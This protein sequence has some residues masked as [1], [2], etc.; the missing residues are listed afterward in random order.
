[1]IAATGLLLRITSPYDRARLALGRAA[2]LENGILLEPLPETDGV[3][4]AGDIVV[5]V[6]GEAITL[7]ADRLL[8]VRWPDRSVPPPVISTYSVVRGDAQ[9]EV[10]VQRSAH[11]LWEDIAHQWGAVIFLT[12]SLFLAFY[13][14]R[15][16][17]QMLAARLFCMAYCAMWV[18]GSGLIIGVHV[19]D[20]VDAGEFWIHRLVIRNFYLLSRI[21]LLHFALIFP[22]PLP[23]LSR[24]SRLASLYLLPY[25]AGFLFVFLLRPLAGSSL[26]WWGWWPLMERALDALYMALF[27]AVLWWRYQRAQP[28]SVVWQQLRWPVAAA[29]IAGGAAILAGFLP[30]IITGKPLVSYNWLTVLGLLVPISLVRAILYDHLFDIDTFINRTLVYAAL[31][32]VMAGI[33]VTVVGVLGHRIHPD[34][35]QQSTAEFLLYL[36]GAALVAIL[37]QPLHA[38]LQRAVNRLMYGERDDPYAVLSKLGQKLEESLV[39]ETVLPIIAE[40]VV[41]ALKLPYAA[42]A[43]REGNEFA[44]VAT[45]GL[46]GRN[47]TELPLIF[48]GEK[49]GQLLVSPRPGEAFHPAEMR[50]LADI[51]HQAGPAVHNLRLNADLHHSRQQIVTA[52]EEERRRLRG[53]LH[54]GL[55]PSLATQGLKLGAV[56]EL[57]RRDADA[58]ERLLDQMM[59]QNQQIVADI[60][61]LIYALRPPA[62][63]ELGLIGSIR[64]FAAGIPRENGQTRP[65]QIVINGPEEDL[66]P[67]SAALEV[68][69][70]RIVLEALTN[71][72]RHAQAHNCEV[73]FRVVDSILYVS[74]ADDGIGFPPHLQPGVGLVSMRDRAE[75]ISG[76]LSW[77]QRSRGGVLIQ[78]RLPIVRA[79]RV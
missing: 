15:Q 61:R 36:L 30:E 70:Y 37:F 14:I 16:R 2:W 56:K 60:R 78:A 20:I 33:Y 44:I 54:D 11:P 68:A 63:D 67:L 7:W 57:L 65:V 55:G 23:A 72:S 79:E 49:I 24:P 25:S 10:P 6:N 21:S 75:E 27:L 62:L 59:A 19:A 4:Q 3:F 38:R 77:Q 40:T 64:D 53:D 71:V 66:P 32:V 35:Q 73:T 76:A 18:G 69:A 8:P 51:A 47:V 39:P 5:A 50:L 31:V 26:L 58:A 43:V 12:S 45:H 48:Q 34:Y 9:L 1:M 42:L 74:I 22:T 28:G 41:H 13:V 29:L 46:S 17:P 52:R